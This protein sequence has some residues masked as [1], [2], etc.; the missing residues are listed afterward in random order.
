MPLYIYRKQIYK[1]FTKKGN[2]NI[3]I[4]ELDSYLSY[5]YPK[6]EFDFKIVDKIKEEEN[7]RLKEI[8]IVE[9]LVKQF[10]YYEYELNTQASIPKEKLWNNY[11]QNS[12]L[13]KDNKFP[14][15]WPQRKE[16]AWIRDN[17]KC[18]RCGTKV[19]L[20]DA[21]PLLAKQMKNGG[22]FNL[23]NIVIL[24]N[25]CSR[26]I[27]SENLEKT[28]KDLKILDNLMRRVTN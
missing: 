15:D 16:A 7:F 3:F 2:I 13:L 25:D 26:V 28:R 20:I 6:I 17:G 9:D 4:K 5:N 14:I 18:N 22:G 21:N 12:R 10:A 1:R 24:C 27:R 11:D 8:L 23:E 19:S